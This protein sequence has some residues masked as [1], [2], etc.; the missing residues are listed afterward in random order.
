[1][2][3]AEQKISKQI[4][5]SKFLQITAFYED[6]FPEVMKYIFVIKGGFR[7]AFLLPHWTKCDFQTQNYGM[8]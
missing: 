5:F 1:M 3:L 7:L 6:N 8:A 4:V 2:L